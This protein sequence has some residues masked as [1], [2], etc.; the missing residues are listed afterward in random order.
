MLSLYRY[1]L[2][3][4]DRIIQ[5]II[6]LPRET[7]IADCLTIIDDSVNNFLH[8][9]NSDHDESTKYF[10]VHALKILDHL[11]AE[12]TLP[13]ILDILEYD[14][15]F[16]EFYFHEN[17][18]DYSY[19][20]LYQLGINQKKLL[21]DF[22]LKQNIGT[23]SKIVVL[24]VFKQ[25]RLYKEMS[26]TAYHEF[27]EGLL[28]AIIAKHDDENFVDSDFNAFLIADCVTF[29][30]DDLLPKIKAIFE[31]KIVSKYICGNFKETKKMIVG[32]QKKSRKLE[33]QYLDTIFEFYEYN[34]FLDL[35]DS[36]SDEH[37]FIEDIDDT[38]V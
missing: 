22:L 7:V 4:S 2:K 20:T 13:K 29:N 34:K 17:L 12:E 30:L 11:R 10:L 8:Y 37:L 5:K 28:D 15:E 3:I 32:N 33:K 26:K 23:S 18:F 19:S 6:D 38:P 31:L 36:L 14:Q 9:Y 24:D 1:D 27:I 35:E 25:Y 21:S 16:I